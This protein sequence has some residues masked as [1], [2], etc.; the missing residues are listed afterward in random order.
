MKNTENKIEV[1]EVANADAL[2]QVELENVDGGIRP[3]DNNGWFKGISADAWG[4]SC[5]PFNW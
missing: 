4:F 3:F 1:T 2:E 5:N